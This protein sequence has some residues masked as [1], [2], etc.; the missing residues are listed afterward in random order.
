MIDRFKSLIWLRYK[1]LLN[2][3]MLLFVCV[4]TPIMDF[5]LLNLIPDIHGQSFFL[6]M[7]IV[8]VYSL[9]AGTFTTLIISE[10]KEKKNLR[11]LIL[12]GVRYSDY[13][14]STV[15]FP[16]LFSV[17][18]VIALP[19][20]FDISLPNIGV[21]YVVTIL[22]IIS[23]ILVNL[24]IALMCKTQTQA[25]AISLI[26]YLLIMMLPM[27]SYDNKVI[28]TITDLSLL[29]AHNKYFQTMDT[30][31]LSDT[32]ILV[33]LVWIMLLLGAVIWAFKWNKKH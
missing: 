19:I 23:F 2:N 17:I 18:E 21:Y 1:Y 16:I 25:S 29:G 31:K 27:F 30:F 28:K 7:G 12:S 4:L 11:T 13:I 14:A 26:F 5:G 9:T 24:T 10:E 20:I 3:K 22:S 6:N 8:T 32:S 15:L 33:T